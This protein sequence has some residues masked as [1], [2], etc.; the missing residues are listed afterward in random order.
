MTPELPT[1]L[2]KQDDGAAFGPDAH[3]GDLRAANHEVD[4]D[5][6]PVHPRRVTRAE[7]FGHAGATCEVAGGVLVQ[8]RRHGD[9]ARAAHERGAVHEGQ[10]AGSCGARVSGLVGAHN[11]RS[12]ARLHTGHH[13]AGER[14]LQVADG[15]P[16]QDERIPDS[17]TLWRVTFC[18]LHEG[19]T[20]GERWLA[21]VGTRGT[22]NSW[23]RSWR[24][25]PEGR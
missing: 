14:Q 25:G 24:S 5:P 19:R 16:A 7:A 15:G 22:I 13:A 10:L 17:G 23:R 8:Q 9:R 21:P 2:T 3:D 12:G 6:A 4:V 18:R 1:L 20:P 11:V